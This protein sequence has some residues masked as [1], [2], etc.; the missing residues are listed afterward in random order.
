MLWL[1]HFCSE[2]H[3]VFVEK[4]AGPNLIQDFKLLHFFSVASSP[5]PLYGFVWLVADG[6]C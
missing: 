3:K 2:V 5:L 1:L 6:W 4:T